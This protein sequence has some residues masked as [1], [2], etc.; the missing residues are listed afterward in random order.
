MDVTEHVKRDRLASELADILYRQE[1]LVACN[2]V[3]IDLFEGDDI[4]T[5]ERMIELDTKHLRLIDTAIN[6]FG[7]RVETRSWTQRFCKMVLAVMRDSSSESYEKLGA[8]ALLK[9]S[10]SHGAQLVHKATSLAQPDVKAALSLIDGL[11]AI[12]TRQSSQLMEMIDTKKIQYVMGEEPEQGLVGRARELLSSTVGAVMQRSALSAD[13]MSV[14]DVL[15]LDHRKVETLFKEIEGAQEQREAFDLYQQLRA[16]LSA[17]AEA[18]EATV[19]RP[20]QKYVDLRERLDDAWAEHEEMRQLLDRLDGLEPQPQEFRLRLE[21]LK[22]LVSRHVDEEENE[23]FALFEQKLGEDELI[24][25]AGDFSQVKKKIQEKL[26]QV[27]SSY[28][29]R[30]EVQRD[31]SSHI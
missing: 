13:E 21:E 30:G 1:T 23:M 19:Y 5:A 12:M 3:V 7:L 29:R 22:Q 4:P 17:H 8:Y 24:R 26:G 9:H 18:E 15:R 2:Q 31:L 16:D 28:D 20:F 6:N 10:Q 11:A 27:V 14:L 25:L